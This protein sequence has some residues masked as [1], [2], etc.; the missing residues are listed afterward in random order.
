M[1][2]KENQHHNLHFPNIHLHSIKPNSLS[3]LRILHN[4]LLNIQTNLKHL[5]LCLLLANRLKTLSFHPRELL[6]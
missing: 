1:L 2:W 5:T 3:R 6:K 4:N